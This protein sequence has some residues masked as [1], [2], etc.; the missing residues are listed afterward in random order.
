MSGYRFDVVYIL[1]EEV[2][3]NAFDIKSEKFKQVSE[4][5]VRRTD[6]DPIMEDD[7]ITMKEEMSYGA[8]RTDNWRGI[9][10]RIIVTDDSNFNP[11]KFKSGLEEA[12]MQSEYFDRVDYTT[13]ESIG[14][15][16]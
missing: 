2:I 13:H 16:Y 9:R 14:N 1:D 12:F 6:Y 7:I 5:I 3:D 8:S 11:E 15:R 10:I 4:Y